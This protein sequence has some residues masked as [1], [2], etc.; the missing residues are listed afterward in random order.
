VSAVSDALIDRARNARIED[1]IERRGIRLK[2]HGAERVGPCPKCGGVDRFSINTRKQVFNCRICGVGG[3]VIALVQHLDGCKFKDAITRL[4]GDGTRIRTTQVPHGSERDSAQ[5]VQQKLVWAD[6][7]WGASSP[8]GQDAIT[9]LAKRRID[10][11]VVPEH[12]GLRFIR[13]ARGETEQRPASSLALLQRSAT[14]R[15]VSG[16]APLVVAATG[17]KGRLVRCPPA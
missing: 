5:D 14:N 16:V 9:Y 13:N 15:A 4:A 12:G 11:D 7:I 1:E 10:I 2:G 17:R 6:Q 8:L 3:D